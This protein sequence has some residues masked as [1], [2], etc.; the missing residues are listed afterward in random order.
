[1]AL[2]Y[3][4]FLTIIIKEKANDINNEHDFF[5]ATVGLMLRKIAFYTYYVD[6]HFCKISLQYLEKSPKKHFR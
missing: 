6:K 3:Y 1:M 4:Y 5:C 2:H